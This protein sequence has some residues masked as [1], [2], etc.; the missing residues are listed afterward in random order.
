MMNKLSA[1]MYLGNLELGLLVK[2]GEK[3]VFLCECVPF[4]SPSAL[5]NF[6]LKQRYN[7]FRRIINFTIQI[8]R[9][10]I[11]DNDLSG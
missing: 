7:F 9:I 11:M 10:K 5:K 3:I 8:M 6:L 2:N 4:S 1:I